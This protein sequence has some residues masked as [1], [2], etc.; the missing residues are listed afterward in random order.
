MTNAKSI[1]RAVHLIEEH[2][3]FIHEHKQEFFAWMNITDWFSLEELTFAGAYLTI[4]YIDM[5]D[6]TK[7]H[8]LPL[9]D[10]AA[11]RRTLDK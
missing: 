3:L 8:Q 9:F 1:L 4:K 10:Y 2:H 6:T 11:W 7:K 5:R